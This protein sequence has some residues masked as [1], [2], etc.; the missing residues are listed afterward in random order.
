MVVAGTDDEEA[1]EATE[2]ALTAAEGGSCESSE[3]N[4]MYVHNVADNRDDSPDGT[5]SVHK[6]DVLQFADGS[7]SHAK[8]LEHEAT[9]L[10][11]R[12]EK[13]IATD[14]PD[15]AKS[16]HK[17]IDPSEGEGCGAAA[18]E[19]PFRADDAELV[20]QFD[21]A[22]LQICGPDGPVASVAPNFCQT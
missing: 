7:I 16:L 1:A 15:K 9:H 2:C 3:W 8:H 11:C 21:G 17:C 14:N 6:I 5:D 10:Q 13:C 22:L 18:L 19:A 4:C 20:A 12:T